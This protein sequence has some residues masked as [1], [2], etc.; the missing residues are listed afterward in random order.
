MPTPL[1]VHHHVLI[2]GLVQ[3]VGFRP[4]VVRLAGKFS[5]RGWVKNTASGVLIAV[6]GES[7]MQ[8]QFLHAL[9][10]QL[11]P[12]AHI[13]RF[14]R[15]AKEVKHFTDF[16]IL[17]S[18][19]DS[20]LS[21]FSLPDIATCA[22]CIDDIFNPSSRY[23]R[24]PFTSCC[25]CGPRYSITLRQPFDRQHTSMAAFML[26]HACLCEYQSVD[27]RRFHAQTIG[28]NDCGVQLRFLSANGH[29]L[30]Q[31]DDALKSAVLALREGKIVAVKG[32][33]GYQLVVDATNE[34]AITRLRERKK[35]AMKPFAIMVQTLAQ[36]HTLCH[37]NTIEENALTSYAAPIVLL[38]RRAQGG[39]AP[40]VSPKRATLG[41]MLPY[42]PLHHLLLHDVARP[43]VVTSGNPQSEPIC[44]DDEQAFEA[45]SGIA[46]YF[47]IHNRPIVRALDDSVVRV[48]HQKTTVLRRARGFAPLPI[49]L[50]TFHDNSPINV[51]AVGGHL[52]NTF[53]LSAGD[54]ALLSP[55]LGDLTTPA[56]Q[57][58]AQHTRHALQHFYDITP[59]RVMHDTHLDYAS[60]H[61]AQ[62]LPMEKQAIQHHYAHAL[63][64]MADNGLR[65]PALGIV[66]DGAGLGLDN[67]LWGGEFLTLHQQGF[68]R[69]AHFRTFPLIGA[70]KAIQE[71]RRA[72]L[73]M[74]FEVYG[75]GA[76]EKLSLPFSTQ[77]IAL[78]K[79]ALT[80]Q[81]NC[82]RTSS[83]GRLF[84]GFSSLLGLC[85]YNDYEGQ[86]AC[87]LEDC[88]IL[89]KN[90]TAYPYTIHSQKPFVVDW[91]PLLRALLK[92]MTHH[93]VAYCAMRLHE[94]FAAIC[95]TIAQIAT[96]QKM[97]LSGGCFQNAL[98]TQRV[99]EH[100]NATG[101]D[102]YSHGQ[103]PPND[104]GL[105]LGQLYAAQ[106]YQK[107]ENS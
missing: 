49:A 29:A 95:V 107:N 15:V 26:C 97:V 94:T 25:H 18:V 42:S 74:L 20:A 75:Q 86:G 102:V 78:M 44:I 55:H 34:K 54:Y 27:N 30:G 58:H 64:C 101:F 72:A 88:A 53:A 21:L 32:I 17:P 46:D 51:L 23:F 8:Q 85:H 65:P 16:A 1:L 84:D 52:K 99:F 50:P 36:A 96:K 98:L 6:E 77:E 4:F 71:P 48:I 103:V 37:I 81:L 106:I 91:E 60:T 73:G 22:A 3:G 89:I 68:S 14:S 40:N 57:K 47:L 38:T 105:S 2:E 24:Y 43:L 80:R 79:M 82:P 35:R 100:L 76:F 45:L 87:I 83:V 31:A 70:E 13:R 93:P 61:L 66:W 28:C 33:G 11:P 59:T 7:A 56:T 9:Q 41:V 10:T 19:H 62:K 92:D 39:V 69:F 5:Q 63:A 104:G 67:T 12:V 90:I